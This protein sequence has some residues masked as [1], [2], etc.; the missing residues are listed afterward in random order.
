MFPR[1]TLPTLSPCLSLS[2]RDPRSL[3]T[4]FPPGA[5]KTPNRLSANPWIKNS[6]VSRVAVPLFRTRRPEPVRLPGAFVLCAPI[7]AL[8]GYIS[9]LVQ[10]RFHSQQVELCVTLMGARI[11][12]HRAWGGRETFS[13]HSHT[14]PEGKGEWKTSFLHRMAQ[15]Q[16]PHANHLHP[17]YLSTRVAVRRARGPRR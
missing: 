10:Q 13:Y 16:T 2:L 3:F 5:I 8:R 17:R 12:A 9:S 14:T 6:P 11:R 15:N 4:S 1:P 7:D